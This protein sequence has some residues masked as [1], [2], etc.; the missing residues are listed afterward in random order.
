[1]DDHVDPAGFNA[2]PP[3]API[4]HA[5]APDGY[6]AAKRLARISLQDVAAAVHEARMFDPTARMY[7]LRTLIKRRQAIVAYW[8]SQVSPCE[9]ERASHNVLVLRDEA[10]ARAVKQVSETRY[11]VDVLDDEGSVLTD[12]TRIQLTSAQFAVLIPPELASGRDRLVVRLHA[13]TRG[14]R[15]QRPCYVHVVPS[16]QG[17]RVIGIQH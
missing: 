11:S 4:A 17:L 14:K 15:R 12:I 6:W 8:Y 2:S 16:A 1:M 9:L 3:F 13:K 10:V 7:L 5:L